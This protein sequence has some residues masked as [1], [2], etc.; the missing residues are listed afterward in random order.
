M[1]TLNAFSGSLRDL[2]ALTGANV[3][4]VTSTAQKVPDLV[5]SVAKVVQVKTPSTLDPL[6]LHDHGCC[7]SA[8]SVDLL[9]QALVPL[10]GSDLQTSDFPYYQVQLCLADVLSPIGSIWRFLL[11]LALEATLAECKGRDMQDFLDALTILM[12]STILPVSPTLSP[13]DSPEFHTFLN[14]YDAYTNVGR[15]LVVDI[16]CFRACFHA[17]MPYGLSCS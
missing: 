12:D 7:T 16:T 17:Q 2:A 5:G 10:I 11:L 14:L 4:A 8:K 1:D 9:V 6:N 3:G 15:M 13:V